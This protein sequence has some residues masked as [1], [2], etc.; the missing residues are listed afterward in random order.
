MTNHLLIVVANEILERSH[1]IRQPL[2]KREA[3]AHEPRDSLAQ[4]AV[5]PLDRIGL[6]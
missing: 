2:G 5:E 6:A 4:G 3:Q 1:V